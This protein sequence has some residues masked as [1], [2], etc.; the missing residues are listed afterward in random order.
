MQTTAK[1]FF[2]HLANTVLLYAGIIALLHLLFRVINVAYPQISQY[3]QY[4]GQSVISF[5]VATLI[6]VFP[7][8][9]ILSQILQKGYVLNPE[10]K[11]YPLRKWLVYITLFLSGGVLAGTLVTLIYYFLDGQELTTG[12][13]LKILSVFVVTGAV[14]GYKLDDLKERLTSGRRN[15]WKVVA[16]VLILGSIILGFS[17]V[18]SPLTQRKIR[19]DSLKINDLQSIQWQIINYWQQKGKIPEK[20]SD[21]KDPISGFVIPIDAQTK[22]PYDY[23]KVGDRAF[24]LCAEFNL[25]SANNKE[26]I[27]YDYSYPA[28]PQS[29]NWVNEAGYQCF[30]RTI[31]A[32]LYPV[33]R[34]AVPAVPR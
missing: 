9:L 15:I 23:E 21:L 28:M 10:K 8:F 3:G 24:K 6:V 20:L 31:D 25:T 33:F 27:I 5:Q 1:D 34:N 30:D 11:E 7:L 14:F 29:D 32:D 12:F 13:L 2:L 19:Y 26:A 22:N 18:G 17:V 4:Y 16:V